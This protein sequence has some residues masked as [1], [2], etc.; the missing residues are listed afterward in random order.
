MPIDKTFFDG[1]RKTMKVNVLKVTLLG[2]VLILGA[3]SSEPTTEPVATAEKLN[4][5]GEVNLAFAS[6]FQQ[7]LEPCGCEFNPLGG[8]GRSWKALHE[9]R[10]AQ[11]RVHAFS[12][13]MT[14]TQ[15]TFDPAKKDMYQR[16]A[17]AMV[18]ALNT[19]HLDAI[20]PAGSD[21]RLGLD[22][23]MALKA[24]AEF[25]FI[26]SD[27][28]DKSSQIPLFE[29]FRE[30]RGTNEVS[31]FVVGLSGSQGIP[32]EDNSVD[33]VSPE[34]ALKM[35]FSE[36]SQ[37]PKVIVLLSSLGRSENEKIAKEFPEINIILGAGDA[38]VS[39][40]SEQIARKTLY[41]SPYQ[42]GMSWAKLSLQVRPGFSAFYNPD[43]AY[44]TETKLASLRAELYPVEEN[45][46]SKPH[47]R[48]TASVA[49]LQQRRKEL[50]DEISEV[51]I[52]EVEPDATAATYESEMK[53]MDLS[54]EGKSNPAIGLVEK[55]KA[56]TRAIGLEK[57]D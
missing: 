53:L 22:N 7:E 14:F 3:C 12:A 15:T 28:Y 39:P 8:V 11:G 52:Q 55:Y 43:V 56:Q 9:W 49:H 25:A 44:E 30:F 34:K 18:E 24:K 57:N 10:K 45:L 31:L 50:L 46:K 23:L 26:S 35:I 17:D 16:K 54:L 27:L 32:K 36:M 42:R 51:S 47:S 41:V 38:N 37:E 33:V 1:G 20:T 4:K 29:R 2:L 48:H 40:G 21:L 19:M 6:S 13:G 5:P